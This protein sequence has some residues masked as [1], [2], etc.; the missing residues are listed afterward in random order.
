MAM[1]EIDSLT[2]GYGS[3][4][5]LEDLSL[6]VAAGSITV[7]LGPNGVGKSTLFKTILGFLPARSGRVYV[8]GADV[9]G[10]SRR[11]FAQSVA[12]VPQTHDCAFGYTVREMV[13]MGRTPLAGSLAGPTA[14]DARM[15]DAVLDDLGLRALSGR[16]FTSLS[17]GEQQMV[18][19]ARAL[20]Q[21][22]KLLIM[23]EP[24]A[25]LD[26]GNQVRVLARIKRLADAGLSVVVTSHDP[27]HALM[28]DCDVLCLGR[29]GTAARLQGRAAD[30]L[31]A[32]TIGELYGIDAAC[33][34]VRGSR[35]REGLACTA[36]LP[37]DVAGGQGASV[38]GA[39]AAT[40]GEQ[41]APADGAA[42]VAAGE[43]AA[44]PTAAGDDMHAASAAFA[45]PNR[46]NQE[47][48]TRDDR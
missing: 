24:C 7:L 19:I 29:A 35:G 21:Q 9:T 20:A 37:E 36:F 1:L 47:K 5:V 40:T 2:C 25:N 16:G 27:N 15:V 28:L 30:V 34:R 46:T 39:A 43:R 17:G 32:D 38:D 13:L 8:E 14:A 33:G 11:R 6:S 48:E 12:Y 22:P 44:A 3:H 10:W 18:L 41:G 26:L 4:V 42:S 45:L 31:N 23:D